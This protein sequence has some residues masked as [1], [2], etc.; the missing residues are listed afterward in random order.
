VGEGLEGFAETHVIGEYPVEAVAGEELHPLEAV[1]LVI[2]ESG[3]DL[4]GCLDLLDLGEIRE[5]LLEFFQTFRRIDPQALQSR[6]R[7][8]IKGVDAGFS[9][10][11]RVNESGEMAQDAA[12]AADGQLQRVTVFQRRINEAAVGPV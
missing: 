4:A 5:P 6:Q 3:S 12:H 10:K 11:L 9:E 2:A 1:F 8:D 7:R